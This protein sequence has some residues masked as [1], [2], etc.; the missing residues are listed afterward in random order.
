[1]TITLPGAGGPFYL[2]DSG[3]ETTL[4]FHEGREL[5]AFAAFPLLE[6]EPD[7]DWL[8]HYYGRHLA[9]A[10][11]HGAGFVL[12]TPTWRANADWGQQLGYGPVDLDR[13]NRDA[14]AFC[15]ALAEAWQDRVAPIVVAGVLG[16]RGDGYVAGQATATEAQDYHTPQL[17][18]FAAAAADL[19]VAYTLGSVEE[20]TGIALA[21]R[22]AGI[23]VAISFTVETD[24]RLAS[25]CPLG[26]AIE[27]VDRASGAYPAYYM[28]NCA[29]PLHFAQLFD[30]RPDWAQRIRGIRANASTLSHAELDESEVLDEGNPADLAQ[31]IA[32]LRGLLPSVTVLGGCCGT[33]HRHVSAIAAAC[34]GS[35]SPIRRG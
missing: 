13:I 8:R 7:R 5:P 22:A 24:G 20:A 33:D 28:I 27:T 34:C 30:T 6:S 4:V 35:G 26:A 19:A 10:A 11:A 14:V 17:V 1:M 32:G 12:D 18:S 15:R 31:R 21:A 2:S 16:P 23:A 3:L 29:H 9:L 25:G